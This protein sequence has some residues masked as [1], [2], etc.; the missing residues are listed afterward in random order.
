MEICALLPPDETNPE[1]GARARPTARTYSDLAIEPPSGDEFEQLQLYHATCG[2][3][4]ALA[5]KELG[6]SI[7]VSARAPAVAISAEQAH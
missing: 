5:R 4:A 7:R 2:G 6:D 1:G 3:E